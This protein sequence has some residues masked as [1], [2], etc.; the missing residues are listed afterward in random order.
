MNSVDTTDKLISLG[1]QCL[2]AKVFRW[3]PGM[4]AQQYDND[5]YL[6]HETRVEGSKPKNSP[7]QGAGWTNN[8]VPNVA[9]SATQGCLLSLIRE[10]VDD[11]YASLLYRA[12]KNVW[13]VRSPWIDSDV[14]QSEELSGEALVR[15]LYD[16]G[17]DSDTKTHL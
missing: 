14:A 4:L 5:G 7:F 8:F 12:D 2:K 1:A 11:P 6:V 15:A 13:E 9:D 3:L 16:I 17:H 10:A